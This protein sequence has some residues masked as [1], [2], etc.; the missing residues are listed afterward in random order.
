MKTIYLLSALPNHEIMLKGFATDIAG[1]KQ[2][3]INY[4]CDLYQYDPKGEI[5]VNVD[6]INKVVRVWCDNPYMTTIYLHE[7]REVVV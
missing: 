3:A 2:L 5:F 7:L 1:I 6:I 4:Y